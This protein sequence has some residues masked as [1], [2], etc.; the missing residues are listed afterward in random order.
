M[1]FCGKQRI[2]GDQRIKR[3]IPSSS[4][5]I[6]QVAPRAADGVEALS[7][8]S[9]AKGPPSLFWRVAAALTYLIPWIDSLTLGKEVY[10]VLPST[11]LLYFVPGEL[12]IVWTH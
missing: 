7:P 9:G 4:T 6:L 11:I 5:R 2:N 3:V 1:I 10:H 8:D 12:C